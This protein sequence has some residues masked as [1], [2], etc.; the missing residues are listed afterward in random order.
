[1]GKGGARHRKKPFIEAGL[2]L[3]VLSK[4]AELVQD[5]KTYELISAQ[6]A[7]DPRGLLLAL[8]MVEDLLELSPSCELHCQ[9]LR[10]SLLRLL[11]IKPHLNNGKHNGSVWVHQRSERITVLLG[12]IRRL[13]RNGM[14]SRCASELTAVELQRLTSIVEKVD[15]TPLEN[16][17]QEAEPLENG[18]VDEPPKKKKIE[19]ATFFGL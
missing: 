12:H 4:H 5:F 10:N 19:R 6:G 3:D 16:G 17:E 18:E 1:M 14:T 9:P 13:A 2:L 7:A 8:D 15:V 11:S